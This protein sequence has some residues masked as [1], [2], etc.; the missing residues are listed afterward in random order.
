MGPR[1]NVKFY[2]VAKGRNIEIFTEWSS[3]ELSMHKY[4][5]AVHKSFEKLGDAINFL[6]VGNAFTSCISIRIYDQDQIKTAS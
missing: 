4:Q 6:I 1:V 3:C 2:S 5:N